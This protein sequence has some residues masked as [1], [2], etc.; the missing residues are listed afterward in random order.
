MGKIS[1]FNFVS[2][3]GFYAGAHGEIDWFK[4]IG[5]DKEFDGYTRKS[6]KSGG[7]LI[8]GR[9]TYDMMKSYWP[10]AEAIKTDPLMADSVDNSPKIVFSRRLKKV[11]EG[12]HWKNITLMKEMNPSVIKRLKTKSDMTILGSG[13]IVEQ[14]S[15]LGLIDEYILIVVPVTLGSGISMFKDVKI[16]LKLLESRSFKNGLVLLRYGKI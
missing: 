10:T 14:F 7:A 4:S 3:D 1:V 15:R 6:A 9:T 16:D 5:K 13:S 12:P 2:V 11:E 8:F